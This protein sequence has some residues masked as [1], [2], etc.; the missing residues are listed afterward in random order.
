ML[1]NSIQL[2]ILFEE[3]FWVGIF[4]RAN[5]NGCSATR[6]IFGPEPSEPEVLAFI[7]EKQHLLNFSEPQLTAIHRKYKKTNPK[8]AKRVAKKEV[9][10][11]KSL[12]VAHE[13][14]EAAFK[15]QKVIKKAKTSIDRREDA[16]QK[17]SLKQIKK[18][19]K[20]RGH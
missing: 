11:K 3:P 10:R 19:E 1:K 20:Q 8:R 12:I 7:T 4:E 17:F 2:T 14:M 5:Q 15:E 18:K 6:V 9:I 16:R 13:N